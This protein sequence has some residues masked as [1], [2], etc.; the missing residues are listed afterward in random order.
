MTGAQATTREDG[1]TE[2]TGDLH[3][4]LLLEVFAT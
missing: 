3:A 2:T 4:L 1:A